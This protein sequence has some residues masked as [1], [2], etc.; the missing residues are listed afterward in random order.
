MYICEENTEKWGGVQMLLREQ[1][2]RIPICFGCYRSL[3]VN[4]FPNLSP[5]Q[6]VLHFQDAVQESHPRQGFPGSQNK[7]GASSSRLPLYLF[8]YVY[9]ESH[10]TLCVCF[11]V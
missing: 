10:R 3:W 1:Y 7:S 2:L 9:Y 11:C 4:S 8:W 6:S 5:R